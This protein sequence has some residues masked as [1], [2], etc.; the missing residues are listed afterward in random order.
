MADKRY[1]FI[2]SDTLASMCDLKPIPRQNPALLIVFLG[3]PSSASSCVDPSRKQSDGYPPDFY[4]AFAVASFSL[5]LKG[6][7]VRGGNSRSRTP[8][9][10]IVRGQKSR[11]GGIVFTKTRP[12]RDTAVWNIL[13]PRDLDKE[14]RFAPVIPNFR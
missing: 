3:D 8:I 12:R 14:G 11:R 7:A 4:P 1:I 10:R 13:P 5:R 9:F 6:D 2:T